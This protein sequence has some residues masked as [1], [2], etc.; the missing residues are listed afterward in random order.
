MSFPKNV[1][2]KTIKLLVM[3]YFIG[4]ASVNLLFTWVNVGLRSLDL[5]FFISVVAIF[6]WNKRS[7]FFIFGIIGIVISLYMSFA[8]VYFYK[9]SSVHMT[10][11]EF[12]MGILFSLTTLGFSIALTYLGIQ[13]SEK[14]DFSLI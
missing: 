9:S 11:I 6:L 1:N 3:L 5:I 10:D 12:I 8:C 14:N 7:I 2:Y 13:P 4:L